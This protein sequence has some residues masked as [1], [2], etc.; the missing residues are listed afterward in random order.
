MRKA[1]VLADAKLT[2]A[3][4]DLLQE[5][6]VRRTKYG[7][8]LLAGITEAGWIRPKDIGSARHSMHTQLLT[9]LS[10]KGYVERLPYGKG[11]GKSSW[12][13]KISTQGV[14]VIQEI[15]PDEL[16]D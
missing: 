6:Y 12:M 8:P 13:Y 3:Q 7:T 11:T 16:D 9:V 1:Y 10:D 5:L 15:N 2:Q 14:D 4:L